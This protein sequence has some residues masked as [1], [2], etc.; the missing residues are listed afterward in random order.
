MRWGLER[1]GDGRQSSR[2]AAVMAAAVMATLLATLLGGPP[3]A[4]AQQQVVFEVVSVKVDPNPQPPP[5]DASGR[6]FIGGR[7]FPGRFTATYMTLRDLV[8]MA[9]DDRTGRRVLATEIQGGPTWMN[10]V[11]FNIEATFDAALL[12]KDTSAQ[13]RQL[14]IRRL[15]EERFRLRVHFEARDVP[16]LDL[17]MARPDRRPG[18]QLKPASGECVLSGPPA[19]EGGG[20]V[21]RAGPQVSAKPP[22][23]PVSAGLGAFAGSSV[24]IEALA[25]MVGVRLGTRVVDRT[26]LE[27]LF[28][29]ALTWSPTTPLAPESA[30]GESLTSAL[31]RQLGLKLERTTGP[32]DMLV[33]DAAERPTEN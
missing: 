5:P 29:I 10:A 32:V 1:I 7:F 26:G 18:P 22:N 15:L 2:L 19:P 16:R 25:V 28:D 24:G 13:T 33:V 17:V 11:R 23:C 21:V 4:L 14:M 3:A 30:A 31:E 27:G 12:E 6:R 20:R 9:Y 8:V